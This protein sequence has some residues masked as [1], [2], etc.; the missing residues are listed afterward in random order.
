M[1]T[2]TYRRQECSKPY[3]LVPLFVNYLVSNPMSYLWFREVSTLKRGILVWAP[4]HWLSLPSTSFTFIIYSPLA[5]QWFMTHAACHSLLTYGHPRYNRHR[6]DQL[7]YTYTRDASLMFHHVSLNLK[8]NLRKCRNANHHWY[9]QHKKMFP[10]D[11]PQ[12]C[13]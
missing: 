2:C 3:Y 8:E 13:T 6:I 11:K 5:L 12:S 9:V 7:I 10:T 4:T 1:A